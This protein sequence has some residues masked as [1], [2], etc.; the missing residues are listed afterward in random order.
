MRK[1][2]VAESIQDVGWGM[3]K[4]FLQ[5]KANW[6]NQLVLFV[7][8]FFPSSKMCGGCKQKNTL[9]TLNEREW[10]CPTCGTEHDRDENAANNIKE[11]GIRLLKEEKIS[12]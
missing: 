1:I 6:A 11:E 2:K 5:Y 9:L 3:F 12:A 4:T 8:R 10:V 7:D